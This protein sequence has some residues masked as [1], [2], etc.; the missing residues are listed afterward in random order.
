MLAMTSKDGWTAEDVPDQ[1]GRRYV[2]TGGNSGIGFEAARVLAQRGAAITLACRST[3]KAASAADAI[4]EQ[5]PDAQV[6][7]VALDLASLA[8]VRSCASSLLADDRPIDV[9]VNNAGIMAVPRGLTADGFELQ[10]GTNHLG[11]FAL[12]GLLLGRV[13]D[14]EAARVV[15]VSSN[16]HK[17]GKMRFDDLQSER[18]YSRFGAYAQSKLANLL[19]TMELERRFRR[20]GFDHIISVA[21]HPGGAQTNLGSGLKGGR[22]DRAL[23]LIEKASSY[24]MQSGAD[25][26][27]PTLRAATDPDAKGGDYFG[28]ANLGEQ[29]GPAVVVKA[30][31]KAYDVHDARGLWEESIRLTG[32]TYEGLDDF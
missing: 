30:R 31:P 15:T 9:L 26:A 6:D 23:D 4:R 32:V 5:T 18:K 8:S 12:T 3:E 22:W 29:R 7:T 11:H 16:A 13:L 2:I 1:S 10:F 19:F 17:A 27:L 20:A 24:V 28:P 14:S 25:G 21:C